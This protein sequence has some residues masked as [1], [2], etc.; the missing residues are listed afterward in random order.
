MKNVQMFYVF[1]CLPNFLKETPI[2]L[3]KIFATGSGDQHYLR[4]VVKLAVC[5]GVQIGEPFVGVG[6]PFVGGGELCVDV[7]GD[8]CVGGG[9]R[10]HGVQP[11]GR[12]DQTFV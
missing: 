8:P 12:L 7:V 10:N 1:V 3:R 2:H 6:E 11:V 5:H 4:M 9:G